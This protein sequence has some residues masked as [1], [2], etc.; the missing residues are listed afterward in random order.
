MTSIDEIMER[1]NSSD[2]R[3]REAAV[4]SLTDL[5]PGNVFELRKA[6]ML[7]DDAEVRGA[8]A[9]G[10]GLI[11]DKRAAPC[12][13]DAVETDAS[14]EVRSEALTSLAEYRGPEILE[15]LVAEVGRPKK[16]RR[17]RQEVAK[18]LRYY[19]SRDSLAFLVT[20]LQDEDVFVRDDAADSLY[21][22]NRDGLHN[23]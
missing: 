13:I 11:G 3:V 20:L 12:L 2:A 19:D 18:Q 10:L 15:C 22:L 16:S 4:D 6:S 14:E 5:M 17:P 1:L 21:E 8:A 9:C 23:T 7:D